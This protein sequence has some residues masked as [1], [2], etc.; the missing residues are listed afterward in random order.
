MEMVVVVFVVAGDIL[1]YH[2]QNHFKEK[3]HFNHVLETFQP[4]MVTDQKKSAY[5]TRQTHEKKKKEQK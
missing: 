2:N 4:R 3:F 5:G 1:V